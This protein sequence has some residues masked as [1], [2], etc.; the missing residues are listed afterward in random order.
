MQSTKPMQ[1][2]NNMMQIQLTIIT[3]RE[4]Q[5]SWKHYSKKKKSHIGISW[6]RL[7]F[8]KRTRYRKS[9]WDYPIIL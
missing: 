4:D 7:P 3:H 6:A 8:Y 1:S 2:E 5:A 9:T